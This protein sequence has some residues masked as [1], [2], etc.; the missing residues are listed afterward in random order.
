MSLTD[1][2]LQSAGRHAGARTIRRRLEAKRRLPSNVGMLMPDAEGGWD[3]GTD[4]PW[5]SP[6]TDAQGRPWA[7]FG[8]GPWAVPAGLQAGSSGRSLEDTE[9]G[10]SEEEDVD[11]REGDLTYFA[12]KPGRG[13][14]R[15]GT[16]M[17]MTTEDLDKIVAS[18]RKQAGRA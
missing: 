15:D 10:D 6:L 13:R 14:G 17:Y 16:N 8:S 4:G 1:L 18:P 3:L 2:L 7:L 5:L 12:L 11:G 9:M